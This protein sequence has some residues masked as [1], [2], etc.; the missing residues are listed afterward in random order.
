MNL[1]P[2]VTTGF[3]ESEAA[4]T[5]CVAPVLSRYEVEVKED[6]VA[7]WQMLRMSTLELY[8]VSD[9]RTCI[10]IDLKGEFGSCALKTES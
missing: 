6:K 7:G 2:D 10:R 3:V 4:D 8:V 1:R 5:K 9:E